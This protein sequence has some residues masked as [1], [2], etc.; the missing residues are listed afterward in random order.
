MREKRVAATGKSVRVTRRLAVSRRLISATV[1]KAR[2]VIAP[3]RVAAPV[4]LTRRMYRGSGA[5]GTPLCAA[6][7]IV[8]EAQ[9]SA[10]TLHEEGSGGGERW[11]YA[12]VHLTECD[13][14][15]RGSTE[16]ESGAEPSE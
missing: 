6:R 14:S 9:R 3:R 5:S 12:S 8:F 16:A 10:A 7:W 4:T 11:N 2:F 1:L 15:D 13:E